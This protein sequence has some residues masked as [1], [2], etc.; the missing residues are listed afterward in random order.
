MA[1]WT[2]EGELRR[3]QHEELM[4]RRRNIT[5]ENSFYQKPSLYRAYDVERYVYTKPVGTS[6]SD[7][8]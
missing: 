8:N 5:P 2:L 7:N 4:A 3:R 1:K 6:H